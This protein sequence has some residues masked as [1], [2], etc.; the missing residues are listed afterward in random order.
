MEQRQAKLIDLNEWERAGGGGNGWSY[1]NRN[2]SSIMLKLNKEEISEE[3]SYRE[4]L[5]SSALYEMGISC[6]RVYDFSQTG[7]DS[8]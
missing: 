6:P 8:G 5:I 2:D 3:I 7:H 4:Y 1:I